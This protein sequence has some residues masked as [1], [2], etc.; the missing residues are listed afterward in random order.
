MNAKKY[1]FIIVVALFAAAA[2]SAFGADENTP[3]T[4][5]EVTT[6]IGNLNG[7]DMGGK[8]EAVRKLSKTRDQRAKSALIRELRQQKNPFVRARIV[9]AFSNNMDTTTA[10]ETLDRL[11]NDADKDV[12]RSA[13]YS[14]GYTKD[15]SA[16]KTLIDTFLNEKEDLNVRCV[17]AGSLAHQPPTEEIFNC[18]S[19]GLQNSNPIIRMQA[20]ASLSIC[21][22]T[23]DR[24][25]AVEA[26][27][28]MLKDD[29]PKV[30]DMA[31]QRLNFL[32]VRAKK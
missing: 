24:K 10:K 20:M 23:A 28:K 27:T 12:R 8:L 32:G 1:I 13:A 26:V 3:L 31:K 4:T 7:G 22:G 29:D 21:F 11:K 25:R 15:N 16:V 6:Q 5:G 17:A 14:L 30:Q 19:Q 9:E 2:I 18:F